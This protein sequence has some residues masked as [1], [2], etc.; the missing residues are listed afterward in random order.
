MTPEQNVFL[1]AM[2]VCLNGH[3]VN[4]LHR[5]CPERSQGHCDRCGAVTLDCCPTCGG[6]LTASRVLDLVVVGTRQPPSHC[7]FC[8]AAF[9]WSQKPV[10][11]KPGAVY[12]LEEFLRRL[13]RVI[14]QLRCRHGDRPPFLV[15][16]EYDLEDLLRSLVVLHFEDFRL[17]TRTPSY[18]AATR[19]DLLLGPDHLAMTVKTVAP[20]VDV[21]AL[22][23][24]WSEDISYYQRQRPSRTLVWFVYDPGQKLYDPERLEKAWSAVEGNLEVRCVVV[25]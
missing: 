17:E 5:S 12:L 3:V 6:E 4:D 9:P 19:Q 8:G 15:Q 10:E 2:Q 21:A 16:D 7:G 23:R 22:S 11:E 25:S 24:Q 20:G 13:P 1:D 14:R 18:A